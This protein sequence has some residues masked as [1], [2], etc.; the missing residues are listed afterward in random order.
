MIRYFAGHP[1]AANLLM[2]AFF[3][4]GL[5]AWPTLQRE[6]FPRVEPRRVEVRILY[7]G[8]RPEDVEETICQ[9]I[10][11]AVDGITNVFETTCEANESLARAVIEMSEGANFDRFTADVKTEIEAIDDFPDQSEK[12]T[13]RQLGRTDFVASVAV[14]GPMGRTDLKAYAEELKDR[15]LGSGGIPKIEIK[16]FSEHQIRIELADGTLRQ[17]GLSV[18]DIANTIRRQSVDLPSGSI[19]TSEQELLIRFADE[20][21]TVD[22]F[23]DL[24]VVSSAGGGQI[25]L[26]DIAA[27]TDRFD[28]DE[29]KIIFNGKP[30]AVLDISK[31]ENEDTLE[32]ID[33]VNAFLERERGTAPPGIGLSVTND[34]SSIVSDRLNLLLR[35]GA[36]GLVLVFLALWLFFGFRYSFWVAMGLPVSFLGAIAIMSAIGYSINMLTM[37][38]LL[39][40]IGLLMDDAIVIAENVASQRSRGKPPLE[41]AIDGARQVLPSVFASFATTTCIFGSLAFLKGDIGAVLRVVPVVMLLVLVISLIEAFIIL[42][43]HLSH[44]L[45]RDDGEQGRIQARMDDAIDWMR[46]RVVGP[47]ANFAVHRRYLTAGCAIA[48]LL[49]TFS[50]I[51]GGFLKFA[52]F[53]ELDGDVMEARILLPQGTPLHKTE[54]VV[55]HISD[56]LTRVNERLSPA[57]PDGHSLIRNV[58]LK[59]NT[60]IDAHETG[61]HVATIVADLLG[62]ETRTSRIDDVM[63]LWR[64]ETGELPDVIFIK[65][66]EPTVGPGGLAIDIRLH[67]RDPGELKKASLELQAWLN[68]YRGVHNV[69]DDLRPGKPELRIRLRDGAS[70]LGI[71]AR[72]IANQLRSALYGTTVSEIQHAGE[73]YEIDVRLDPRDRNSLA[74]LDYF[75]VTTAEGRLVPLTAVAR[76]EED[77]GY[78]RI[79]RVNGQRT[80]TIQGDIDKRIGN[81]NE[82]LADTRKHFFPDMFKRYPTVGISLQGAEKEAG[83]TQKSMARGFVIGLIG[84]FLLLSFLFRSYVEPLVVMI[85]IPFAFI[86]AVGGHLL[87][88][89]DFTMPS[90]LGFAAL[91][92]VVVNNSILLVNFI[93]HYHGDTQSVAEAAPLA[94]QARFRAILLTSLTTI[95]GLLPILSETSLQAQVLIPLVVSLA[96][97]ILAS[98]VLVLFLVPAFYAILDDMGLARLD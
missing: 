65:F 33:A 73:A 61:P 64:K 89:L 88:G 79:N 67:G 74:D 41:A 76:I 1:T 40:V 47:L 39:I 57:Q 55:Q 11:D 20:R 22:E 45:S 51:A 84:V 59:F 5:F 8:A 83:T 68:R 36:Q 2:I 19:Q 85:I 4:A 49:L 56:A 70:T 86:G 82:I 97:G 38:G 60:N 92:G 63:A 21:K 30:A 48:L 62:S 29:E 95:V 58:M 27:I 44:A 93:K 28:L 90:V 54:Q 23:R 9:R 12:P 25:R 7:P 78:S 43:H 69:T 91:A 66:T 6:T 94:A 24:V 14:T 81:T 32:V 15:M 96:F 18:A 17:F 53:P 75:T 71:D 50:V 31:T 46:D 42:P 34:I 80:V 52:A 35:N 3:V 98:T 16:G 13:V 72:T 37:V 10:E 26:G 77:R 87:L